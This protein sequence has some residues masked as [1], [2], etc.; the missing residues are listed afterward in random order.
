MII[1]KMIQGIFI[2]IIPQLIG[3]QGILE[4]NI[5][6]ALCQT[7]SKEYFTEPDV[8]IDVNNQAFVNFSIIKQFPPDVQAHFHL[9]GASMGEY[10]I[11]TGLDFE[12]G[13]CGMFDEPVILAPNLK[14]FGF[15]ATDCPPSPGYWG[16]IG[17]SLG[18]YVVNT[19]IDIQMPLCD[20]INEPVI[21]GP[22]LRVFGFRE[23]NCPPKMGVYGSE[24]YTLST[25]TFPDDFPRNQ[26]KSLFELTIEGKKL[27]IVNIFF[28]IQ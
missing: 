8:Y 15:V 21:L 25:A 26:Y 3:I 23:D 22:L 1:K 18:E 19:G 20:M 17:A 12:M 27:I 4:I 13:F 16:I 11:Q 9:L 28:E 10:V 14:L 5:E 6:D 7:F 2:A 24:G